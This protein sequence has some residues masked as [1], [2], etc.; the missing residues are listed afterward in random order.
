MNSKWELSLRCTAVRR[1]SQSFQ[2]WPLSSWHMVRETKEMHGF[3]LSESE[4]DK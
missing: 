1:H 3:N 2:L 4:A